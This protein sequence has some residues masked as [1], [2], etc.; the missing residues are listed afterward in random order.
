MDLY[1]QLFNYIMRAVCWS[2]TCAVITTVLILF[3]DLKQPSFT[4]FILLSAWVFIATVSWV[5]SLQVII[6]FCLIL[7][8]VAAEAID[9]IS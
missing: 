5:S 9:P 7:R 8:K 6:I 3:S 4:H 1:G 2:F